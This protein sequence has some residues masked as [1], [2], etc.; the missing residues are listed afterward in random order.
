MAKIVPYVF[1]QELDNNG[2]PL[3]GGKIE[4]FEAGT[5]TNKKTFTSSDESTENTNPVILDASGRADIWLDTG[6]Y[7]FVIKDSADVVIATVDDI[8][9]GADAGYGL[10]VFNKT[11]NTSITTAFA[12]SVV[13][14]VGTFTLSLLD[15]ASA[16][17][18]GGFIF[19]VRNSGSGVITIDPDAAETIDGGLTKLIQPDGS[20]NVV[21]NED[22]DTWITTNEN[23]GTTNTK[24]MIFTG[25]LARTD[26]GELT[27]ATGAITITGAN[28]T[29]D[30]EADAATDDLDTISG[31]SNGAFVTLRAENAGRSVVVKDGTGNI[32][33]PGGEDITLSG[34]ET[35]LT[36]QYDL[37]LAKWLVLSSPSDAIALSQ[38]Y[39]NGLLMSNDSD[40]DHDI[41]IATGTCRDSA[42]GV[43]LPLTSILTKQIDAIFAAGD[44]AGGLFTGSVTTTTWY[45]MF[46]IK[47][48]SDGTIDAG[49]DTSVIAANIPSGYTEFRR[50]GAVL[51]DGSSNILAFTQTNDYFRWAVPT[52]DHSASIST[53]TTV[54]IT[55]PLG[56]ATIGNGR[57]QGVNNQSVN[58]RPVGAS[59]GTPSTT[60]TPLAVAGN[61]ATATSP[62]TWL[63]PTNTS[64]QIQTRP[65]TASNVY[66]VTEG[67][68]DP[69]GKD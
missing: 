55:T 38:G 34:T 5:S 31:V 69:R 53:D 47:K 61:N 46:V 68:F 2:D 44:D 28:H 25:K 62:G 10:T 12:N 41:A 15:I 26:A 56:V 64:S 54:T 32:E 43:N 18:E 50:I 52:L 13:D 17:A 1:W 8:V 21:V 67:Y 42:D 39:I 30:T 60:A 58:V 9:G 66:L 11:A 63:C 49:F 45:H 19:V 65:I 6:A 22:G 51:T 7:K 23:Y 35:T 33:T 3:A 27:I 48:D 57:A 36:L 4:T 40:A 24:D 20:V 37:A 14:C 29:V 59:D 16:V